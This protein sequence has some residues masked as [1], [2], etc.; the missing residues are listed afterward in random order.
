MFLLLVLPT[1]SR[2]YNIINILLTKFLNIPMQNTKKHFD[3][4]KL[5]KEPLILILPYHFGLTG[6]I[7]V[8]P[9]ADFSTTIITVYFAIKINRIFAV[10]NLA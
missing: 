9:M 4:N 6:I 1:I 3:F 10:D 7:C 5:W 8:Q 2:S